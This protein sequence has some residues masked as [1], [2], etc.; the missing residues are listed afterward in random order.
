MNQLQREQDPAQKHRSILPLHTQESWQ[1][2]FSRMLHTQYYTKKLESN[3]IMVNWENIQDFKK[4]ETNL[5]Q[6]KWEDYAKEREQEL[7]V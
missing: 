4:H 5:S 1:H 3:W 6:M 7:M 2:N